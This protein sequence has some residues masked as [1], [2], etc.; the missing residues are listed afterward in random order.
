MNEDIVTQM[1]WCNITRE[2]W[3]THLNKLTPHQTHNQ[4][5]VT[6]GTTAKHKEGKLI[7]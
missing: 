6:K 7:D 1:I 3:L 2:I 4:D 5:Y